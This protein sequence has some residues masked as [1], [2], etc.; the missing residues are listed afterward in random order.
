LGARQ[1]ASNAQ[2]SRFTDSRLTPDHD[3]TTDVADP[4]DQRAEPPDR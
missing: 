3:R 4:L 1:L 2:Q